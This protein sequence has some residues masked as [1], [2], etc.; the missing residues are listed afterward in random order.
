MAYLNALQID[1]L[2]DI[3]FEL[4][5]A[6]VALGLVLFWSMD[7]LADE[8]HL[9]RIFPIARNILFYFNGNP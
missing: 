9:L 5:C 4:Y 3:Y 1:V 8:S 2:S 6:N 7:S